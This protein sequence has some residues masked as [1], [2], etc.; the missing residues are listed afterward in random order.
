MQWD[1]LVSTDPH[2][3][4]VLSVNHGVSSVLCTR[5]TRNLPVVVAEMRDETVKALSDVVLKASSDEGAV[6]TEVIVV[7]AL[8]EVVSRVFN[9]VVVGPQLCEC[10]FLTRVYL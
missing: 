4:A 8:V 2:D 7:D 1:Q 9:R 3:C 6:W 5:L 10:I